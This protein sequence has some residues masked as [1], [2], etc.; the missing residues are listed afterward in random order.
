MRPNPFSLKLPA[1][2]FEEIEPVYRESD[3]KK[4][5]R[6]RVGGTDLIWTEAPMDQIIR[7][8]LIRAEPMKPPSGSIFFLD[9]IYE[10]VIP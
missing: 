7:Q 1:S 5:R 10:E 2:I 6:F 8:T 3:G 4:L 9:Y